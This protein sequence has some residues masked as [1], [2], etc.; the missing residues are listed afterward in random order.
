[1]PDY[2]FVWRGDQVLDDVLDSAVE[3][4][5]SLALQGEAAVRSRAPVLTGFLR[6]SV[7][8]FVDVTGGVDERSPALVFGDSAEYA[9]YVE[10]GTRER[11][12]VHF[13][14]NG[15]LS[16]APY[17]A[18]LIGQILGIRG[19]SGTTSSGST[20]PGIPN[21]YTSGPLRGLLGAALSGGD[22]TP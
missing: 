17:L 16:V 1:M 2:S 21:P 19:Y 4:M 10:L 20:G 5:S 12:G 6:D 18:P 7:Y 13:I 8:V 3:A 15:A 14:M 9:I 22:V 11:P